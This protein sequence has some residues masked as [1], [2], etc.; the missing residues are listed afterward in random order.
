[1]R[2]VLRRA[3]TLPPDAIV[4]GSVALPAGFYFN[5]AI[6]FLQIHHYCLMA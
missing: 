1:L 3:S 5:S 2:E 4:E 6:A